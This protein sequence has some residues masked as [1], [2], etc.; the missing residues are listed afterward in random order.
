MKY[1]I[2]DR[3]RIKESAWTI[4][5]PSVAF[6]SEMCK[7]C[8]NE[9]IV[10]N[11]TTDDCYK[12]EEVRANSSGINGDGYWKWVEEWIEDPFGVQLDVKDFEEDELVSLLK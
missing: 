5:H 1:N 10:R 9:Y 6:A 2:G 7:F 4:K 3:V 8:G 12:L 11:I